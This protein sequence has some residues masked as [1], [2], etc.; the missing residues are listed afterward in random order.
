VT[1]AHVLVRGVQTL[2]RLPPDV[3]REAARLAA[4]H[5]EA[6]HSSV[7][8]VDYTFR[9]YVRKPRGSAPGFVTYTGEKTLDVKPEV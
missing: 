5:S 6:K 7:V 3:L 4:A 8:P 9:R 1:G 2:D